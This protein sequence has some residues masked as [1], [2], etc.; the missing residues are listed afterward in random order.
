MGHKGREDFHPKWQ[1]RGKGR[2]GFSAPNGK[3]EEKG[4]V[5]F[6]PQKEKSRKRAVWDFRPKWQNRRK[7]PYASHRPNW[8]KR[9]KGRYE[10][11]AQT[12]EI[13]KKGGVESPPKPAEWL[14]MADNRWD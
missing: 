13:D 2:C 3:I 1:N 8:K 11:T 10:A 12:D 14:L 5:G 6:P 4:G 7:G 9:G